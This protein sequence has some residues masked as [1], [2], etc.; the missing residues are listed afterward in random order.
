[1]YQVDLNSDLGESFGRYV[2]EGNEEIMKHVTSANIACGFHAGDPMVMRHTV[3]MA[4]EHGVG[5]GAHPG[6]PDLQGFGR[7]KM[8]L[9][10]DE[11]KN[12]VL[13]QLGAIYAFAKVVGEPVAHISAHGALGN[14]VQADAMAA[15]ALCQACYEFDPS[16][17]VLYYGK[18]SALKKEA[19]YFGLPT[20]SMVFADRAYLE[21][22]NLVPR[23]QPGAMIEDK[24]EAIARVIRMI[25]EGK[26]QAIT[27]KDIEVEAETVLVHGDGAHAV[28]FVTALEK[29]FE[30]ENI[31]IRCFSK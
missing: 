30:E 16:I 15:K 6:Y 1:M 10:Y 27:G 18:N 24:D 8:V 12:L 5:I 13:Y 3:E 4:K 20:V 31:A 29:A 11:I 17:R 22:G 7:R 21:D 25:K 2:L 19:D 23:S 9:T 26:V 28:E 14:L